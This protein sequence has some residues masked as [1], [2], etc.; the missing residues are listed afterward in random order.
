MEDLGMLDA[1]AQRARL[2][3]HAEHGL[4]EVQR[5]AVARIAD[6][7]DGDL[8]TRP[9]SCPPPA[10]GRSRTA[11]PLTPRWPGRSE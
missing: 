9:S 8:E 2:R 10:P 6:G 4:D 3:L 11:V 5:L 1:M 7:V